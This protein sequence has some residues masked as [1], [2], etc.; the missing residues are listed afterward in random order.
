MNATQHKLQ[1]I[2]N[3]FPITDSQRRFAES[4]QRMVETNPVIYPS[5]Q[6][7]EIVANL[8]RHYLKRQPE[9]DV[10]KEAAMALGVL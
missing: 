7:S 4:V 5:P 9:G 10:E 6:Q 1:R 2:L 3:D 8:F